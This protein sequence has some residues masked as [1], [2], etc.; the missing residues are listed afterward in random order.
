MYVL[1]TGTP[2]FFEGPAGVKRLP[3]LAQRLHVDFSGD[4]RFES[5]K[6]PQIRL[7]PFELE[8][9]VEAGLKV[10]E[11]Y[12]TDR[13]ERLASKVDETLMRDLARDVAGQLGQQLGVAPRLFLRKLVEAFD[14]VDEFDDYEPRAFLHSTIDSSAMK[15]E[16]LVAAGRVKSVDDIVFDLGGGGSSGES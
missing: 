13:A 4:P 10:R 14:K 8:R 12:P 16:E 6:A 1:I 5:T 9:L 7:H 2:Q 3:P 15:P 11:L